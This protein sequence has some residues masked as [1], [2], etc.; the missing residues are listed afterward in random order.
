MKREHSYYDYLP[1]ALHYVRARRL[2]NDTLALYYA[3]LIEYNGNYYKPVAVPEVTLQNLVGC[4]HKSFI[5]Y[6]KQLLAHQLITVQSDGVNAAV[7][8]VELA[9]KTIIETAS[10]LQN[11]RFINST[12]YRSK[13]D[14]NRE[15]TFIDEL[16]AKIA[17][18]ETDLLQKE[19]ELYQREQTLIE[20]ENLVVA[21]QQA[22]FFKEY[23]KWK[24]RT[25]DA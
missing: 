16:G 11:I 13:K 25:D 7:Y 10:Q 5:K 20:S 15:Q 21:E 1:N 23:D 18:R 19:A 6:R 17:R 4:S 14:L 9:P 2:S 8:T 22:E 12:T 24:N 3:I